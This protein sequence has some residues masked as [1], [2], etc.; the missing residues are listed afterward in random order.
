MPNQTQKPGII[1]R[2][3]NNIFATLLD[4]MLRMNTECV[5]EFLR[6]LIKRVSTVK[7]VQ[8]FIQF[9][10]TIKIMQYMH[11]AVYIQSKTL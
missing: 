1:Q 9:Y 6:H 8:T 2:N 7:M 5:D 3:V 11:H 10:T 4:Q